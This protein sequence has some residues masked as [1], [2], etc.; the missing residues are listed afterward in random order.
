MKKIT[1]EEQAAREEYY[2]TGH[3]AGIKKEKESKLQELL[4]TQLRVLRSVKR[5]DRHKKIISVIQTVL[6][7][8]IMLMLG[9]MLL[10][11]LV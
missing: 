8:I 1:K 9:T 2:N 4:D 11:F 6:F 10:I 7:G 5:D 3:E